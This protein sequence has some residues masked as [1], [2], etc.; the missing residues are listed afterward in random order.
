VLYWLLLPD[1]SGIG[2]ASGAL[3]VSNWVIFV[4]QEILINEPGF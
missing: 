3:Q 2:H 4:G 1:D